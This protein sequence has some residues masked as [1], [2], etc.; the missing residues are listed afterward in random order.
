MCAYC[1]YTRTH[2]H[3]HIHGQQHK[4][5]LS[6]RTEFGATKWKNHHRPNWT[7]IDRFTFQSGL[8]VVFW[9][10]EKPRS[11]HKL[12]AQNHGHLLFYDGHWLLEG[13][14]TTVNRTPHARATSHEP[15]TTS[16]QPRPTHHKPSHT[17]PNRTKPQRAEPT[18]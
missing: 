16:H 8:T 11:N 5:T 12:H 13:S 18:S 17:E 2:N 9:W 7:D 6:R 14:Q 4:V 15:H 3:S 10:V 1:R